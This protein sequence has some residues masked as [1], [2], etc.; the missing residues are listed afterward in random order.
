[1]VGSAGLRRAQQQ[2]MIVHGPPQARIPI[3][4][5]L[6]VISSPC[7]TRARECVLVKS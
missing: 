6:Y 5:L 2:M 3:P 1:M 4:A 7:A